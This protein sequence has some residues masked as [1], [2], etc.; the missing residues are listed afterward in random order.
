M[1]LVWH[2]DLVPYFVEYS[3][4]FYGACVELFHMFRTA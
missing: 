2:E 4:S 1:E 3:V